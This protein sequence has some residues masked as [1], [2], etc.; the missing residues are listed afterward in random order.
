M[1]F[2]AKDLVA[3]VLVLAIAVPYVGYLVNGEM[4]FVKDP[5]GMSGVGLVLGL[6][7]FL[8]LQRGDTFDQLYRLETGVAAV[9]LALGFFTLGFAE[10]AAAD[11][12]L[13]VFMVS[14]LIVW[15]IKLIDHAG[16]LT[17]AHQPTGRA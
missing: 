16:V 9:S 1:R 12:L 15:A 3:S 17:S 2:K 11:I 5:R 6:V 10:T 7:A 8:V 4:P 14:I 13:A